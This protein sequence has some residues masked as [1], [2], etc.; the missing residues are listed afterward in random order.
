MLPLVLKRYISFTTILSIE[1][2]QKPIYMA[3]PLPIPKSNFILVQ[4]ILPCFA[5]HHFPFPEQKKCLCRNQHQFQY[6]AF[7]FLIG[8]ISSTTAAKKICCN[9]L[10]PPSTYSQTVIDIWLSLSISNN[11]YTLTHA[12]CWWRKYPDEMLGLN[13]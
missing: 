3:I 7:S 4:P 8:K 12:S 2:V 10:Q 9:L 5:F 1:I 11:S 6:L 13:A